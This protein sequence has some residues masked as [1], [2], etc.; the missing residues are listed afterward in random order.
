VLLLSGPDILA[1]AGAATA[2]RQGWEAAL[3]GELVSLA[4]S[5]GR[6]LWLLGV[7]RDSDGN[8]T[9]TWSVGPWPAVPAASAAQVLVR[10]G[11]V[12]AADMAG[13]TASGAP[14][15]YGM[16]RPGGQVQP[17]VAPDLEQLR[18]LGYIGD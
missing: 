10:L 14:P 15:T 17:R 9:G 12:P 18:S 11:I 7:G 8:P 3:A 2:V 4:A 5:S 1:R 6:D 16:L 13:V